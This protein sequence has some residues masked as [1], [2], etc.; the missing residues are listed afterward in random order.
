MQALGSHSSGDLL[1]SR[2]PATVARVT[3]FS[4]A[5]KSASLISAVS[6]SALPSALNSGFHRDSSSV[7]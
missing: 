3:P 7:P 5:A 2:I 4:S 1:H 6:G